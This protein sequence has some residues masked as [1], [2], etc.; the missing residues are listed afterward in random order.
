MYGNTKDSETHSSP[1]KYGHQ[2]LP[3]IKGSIPLNPKLDKEW[4]MKIKSRINSINT[5]M[6]PIKG[7][8]KSQSGNDIFTS[9][10]MGAQTINTSS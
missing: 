1:G 2:T 6:S 5:G 7:L 9:K 10:R 8:R 4:G 3:N